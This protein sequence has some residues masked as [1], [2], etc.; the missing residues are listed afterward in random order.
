MV[1]QVPAAG[2]LSCQTGAM[3]S[4]GERVIARKA[5]FQGRVLGRHGANSGPGFE[6]RSL[7]ENLN[8]QIYAVLNAE[9][10]EVR[11]FTAE[12]IEPIQD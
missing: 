10:G 11:F 3:M 2:S 7:P 9:T 12:G 6:Y 5:A 4:P 8:V 1:W